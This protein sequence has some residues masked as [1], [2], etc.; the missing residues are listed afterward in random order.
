LEA[1]TYPHVIVVDPIDSIASIS[2]SVGPQS[3]AV[4]SAADAATRA[5]WFRAMRSPAPVSLGCFLAPG[6][7]V[8]AEIHRSANLI[9]CRMLPVCGADIR[10]PRQ[11]SQIVPPEMWATAP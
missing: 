8:R 5:T 7:P 11:E 2:A 3:I 9:A 1:G 10:V 6:R 4:T